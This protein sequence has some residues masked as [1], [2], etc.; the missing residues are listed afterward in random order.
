MNGPN[1]SAKRA[2]AAGAAAAC[3][4][5]GA[6]EVAAVCAVSSVFVGVGAVV[7]AGRS[8]AGGAG[9]A[10][11]GAGPSERVGA[12]DDGDRGGTARGDPGCVGGVSIRWRRSSLGRGPAEPNTPIH[13][14]PRTAPSR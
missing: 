11:T 8:V 6:T 7:T 9:V 2:P 1:S 5:S 12:S 4:A 3:P 14:A 13:Q 10:L